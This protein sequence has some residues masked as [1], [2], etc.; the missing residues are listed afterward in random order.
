MLNRVGLE[1]LLSIFLVMAPMT[2]KC[3]LGISV[4]RLL[5]LPI[6]PWS[7]PSHHFQSLAPFKCARVPQGATWL[8]LRTALGY[9]LEGNI[10]LKGNGESA[11]NKMG[12]KV[13]ASKSVNAIGTFL[14]YHVYHIM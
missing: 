5:G 11:K 14:F 4:I 3:C 9:R 10:R 7:F 8:P 6:K 13:T 1:Q 12:E 2:I